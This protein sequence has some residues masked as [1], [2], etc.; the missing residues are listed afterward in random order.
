LHPLVVV[1]TPVVVPAL[2]L[3]APSVLPL[4]IVV[5]P[6]LV[7]VVWSMKCKTTSA[8]GADV[9]AAAGAAVNMIYGGDG[10]HDDEDGSVGHSSKWRFRDIPIRGKSVR[11]FGLAPVVDQKTK[12]LIL[13]T[14]PSDLSLSYPKVRFR[15][16]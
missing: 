1:L 5:V 16:P 6:L 14:L 10:H 12:I 7:L 9:T 13:G 15:G 2:A 3:V 11:K 4:A 8:Q